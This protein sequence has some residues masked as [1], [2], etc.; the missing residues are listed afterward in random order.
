MTCSRL[1]NVATLGV[2][3][4]LVAAPTRAASPEQ[5]L[6]DWAKAWRSSKVAAMTAFYEDSKEVVAWESSGKV[7]EG[8]KEI[9][10]MYQDAFDEVVFETAGLE[11]LK[12][13][14]QGDVAWAHGRFKADTTVHA[15]KSRW[16]LHVRASFVLKREGESWKIVFE[17]FSPLPDIPR[18][19]RR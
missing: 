13:R 5:V 3:A 16:L 11:E 4:L 2:I 14:Q 1:S 15:D 9:R 18:V 12:V 10:Q 17:H 6:R 19:Q 7:R 8:A